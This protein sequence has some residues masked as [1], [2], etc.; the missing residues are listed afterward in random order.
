MSKKQLK[1][2]LGE[3][4]ANELRSLVME[5]YDARKE[6]KEYLDFFA[7]PDVDKLLAKF[8]AAIKKEVS[9]TVRGRGKPR[10]SRVRRLLA[11]FASLNPGDR[12]VAELMV[13]TIETAVTADAV[14]K[15][16]DAIRASFTRQVE[17]TVKFCVNHGEALW[18]LTRLSAAVDTIHG[19]TNRQNEFKRLLRKALEDTL[20]GLGIVSGN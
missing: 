13:L 11:D 2:A 15:Y 1:D 14:A 8:R 6:A 3:L 5:L 18:S 7:N 19:G 20:D 10:I 4:D 12:A 17:L 16:S 9:R